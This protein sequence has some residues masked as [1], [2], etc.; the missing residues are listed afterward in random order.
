MKRQ[1]K[2]AWA[3]ALPTL[4]VSAALINFHS[5]NIS[6]ALVM[7][8]LCAMLLVERYLQAEL[9]DQRMLALKAMVSEA[10]KRN[11]EGDA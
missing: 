10:N 3:V 2:N 7:L 8:L 1:L 9:A 6:A 5:G 11:A 4:T